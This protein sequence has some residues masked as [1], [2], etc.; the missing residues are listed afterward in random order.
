M[1]P[2][3][4]FSFLLLGLNLKCGF[5]CLGFF[6]LECFFSSVWS[7]ST[8]LLIAKHMN[9]PDDGLSCSHFCLMM[10]LSFSSAIQGFCFTTR[11]WLGSSSFWKLAFPFFPTLAELHQSCRD[12][13]V[14]LQYLFSI[15]HSSQRGSHVCAID[16]TL[17]SE[18]PLAPHSQCFIPSFFAF[19]SLTHSSNLT[20]L[21]YPSTEQLNT[22]IHHTLLNTL[23]VCFSSLLFT[24]R[25][26]SPPCTK[27]LNQNISGCMVQQ[28]FAKLGT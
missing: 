25:T 20:K 7:T 14:G 10:L 22:H 26:T 18:N 27:T 17:C 19:S 16:L 21:P 28:K 8:I 13:E 12:K 24:S 3:G 4:D 15:G 6:C 1:N 11:C 5:F 23:T 9:G 2:L